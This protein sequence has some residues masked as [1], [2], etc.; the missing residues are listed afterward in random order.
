MIVAATG[1]RVCDNNYDNAF[2]A[3]SAARIEFTI[4]VNHSPRRSRLRTSCTQFARSDWW[5]T[6]GRLRTAQHRTAAGQRW[7][8]RSL[9]LA[10]PVVVLLDLVSRLGPWACHRLSLTPPQYQSMHIAPTY[11]RR[12]DR[13]L[14]LR[15]RQCRAR[16][17]K[18]QLPLAIAAAAVVLVVLWF[19]PWRGAPSSTTEYATLRRTHPDCLAKLEWRCRLERRADDAAPGCI[20]GT[21]A[22]TQDRLQG[23]EPHACPPLRRGSFVRAR[24]AY[25]AVAEAGARTASAPR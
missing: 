5:K 9:R 23:D 12:W 18:H 20:D 4:C 3:H 21:S 19:A 10:G 24:A 2:F 16:G 25:M 13:L 1:V 22:A 11:R 14:R 15:R 17:R 8:D 7:L 6:Q